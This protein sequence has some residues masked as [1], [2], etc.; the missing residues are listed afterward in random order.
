MSFIQSFSVFQRVCVFSLLLFSTFAAQ[1]QTLPNIPGRLSGDLQLNSYFFCKDSAIGAAG[2]PLYDNL[3]SGGEAWL[4]VNYSIAGFDAGVRFDMFQHSNLHNPQKAYTEQGLGTWYLRKNIKELTITAGY[5]YDQIGTGIIFRSYEDRGLGIDYATAGLKLEYKLSENWRIKAF[6]GRQKNLFKLYNPI[7]KG[8]QLDGYI[9]IN[10]KISLVPGAGM[11]NRTID[12]SSMQFVVNTIKSYPDSL[13]FYPRY[14]VYAATV[15][16]TLNIGNFSWYIE[17]AYKTKEAGYDEQNRLQNRDGNVLYSTLSYSVTGFGVTLQGKRTE[18][19]DVRTS[20]NER[21]LQ[22]VINFLPPLT[23]QNSL[24]LPAR[25][26]AA[27]MPLGEMAGQVDFVITP[28][29][30]YTINLNYSNVQNLDGEQLYQEVYGDLELT[31]SNTLHWVFGGQY[32]FY[33]QEIYRQKP[34]YPNVVA[35]TPFAE[36][37]YK[38]NRKHSIRTELQYQS[39]QQDYGSWAF[40]LLEYNAAPNWS[41]AVSDMYNNDPNPEITTAKNHYYN[42]F[43]AYTH[44][45]N[46]F[47]LQYV[48]QVEGINC[49]GGVCRYEP[50]FSGVKFGLTSSF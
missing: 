17:G 32:V 36:I 19:F 31:K 33:N 50:A 6:T 29:R 4:N 47:S 7:I 24:R 23:R 21:L 2:N 48:K 42:L 40:V 5:F 13:R 27:T 45:A 20:P 46:R 16:N 15:F 30:G 28:K 39:T 37:T 1:A 3:L 25:Y 22:G 41:F 26:N 8:G 49:T 34:G 9:N 18:N 35:I 44:H 43:A 10:D 11:I 38:I 14:N 12:Q